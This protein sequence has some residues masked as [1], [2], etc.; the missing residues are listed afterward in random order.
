M[1]SPVLK[2]PAPLVSPVVVEDVVIPEGE[3]NG[4][5]DVVPEAIPPP[6]VFRR[7]LGRSPVSGS[8]SN[9]SVRRSAMVLC[10]TSLSAIRI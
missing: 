6:P 2:E 8:L 1:C 10:R 7:F 3:T 5:S 9:G 4:P